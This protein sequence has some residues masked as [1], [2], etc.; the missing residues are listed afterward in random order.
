MA[1]VLEIWGMTDEWKKKKKKVG[2]GG[3]VCGIVWSVRI[4]VGTVLAELFELQSQDGTN[5]RQAP[6]VDCAA[7]KRNAAGRDLG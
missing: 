6:C 7:A 2:R 1:C 5:P 3:G 4:P